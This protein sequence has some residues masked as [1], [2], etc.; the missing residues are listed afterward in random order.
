MRKGAYEDSGK[1]KKDKDENQKRK[2]L[3][4]IWK[5]LGKSET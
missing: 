3:E 1:K 2:N 5:F 4:K